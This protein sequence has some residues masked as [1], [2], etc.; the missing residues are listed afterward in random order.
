MNYE[1]CRGCINYGMSSD[2][3]FFDRDC[4]CKTCLVKM[5]CKIGTIN[6]DR[7]CERLEKLLIHKEC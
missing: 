5:T 2:C 6:D 3:G 7:D 1:E 4:P